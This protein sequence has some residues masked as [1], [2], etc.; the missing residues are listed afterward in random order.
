M[1]AM[2]PANQRRVLFTTQTRKSSRMS[3][4][5]TSH[6][7]ALFASIR[8]RLGPSSVDPRKSQ[9]DAERCNGS[10]KPNGFPHFHGDPTNAAGNGVTLPTPSR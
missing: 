2:D 8:R 1:V 7:A 6:D 9:E 5:R 4:S 10:R 3:Q